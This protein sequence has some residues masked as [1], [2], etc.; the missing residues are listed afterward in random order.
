[1]RNIALQQ[2]SW[3]LDENESH[4]ARLDSSDAVEAAEISYGYAR[5]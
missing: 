2:N 1:M 3:D 4:A 5:I